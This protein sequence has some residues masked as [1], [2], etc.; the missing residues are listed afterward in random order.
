MNRSPRYCPIPGGITV[1]VS[2]D[3]LYCWNFLLFSTLSLCI[4]KVFRTSLSMQTPSF[5]SQTLKKRKTASPTTIHWVQTT[6]YL[7]SSLFYNNFLFLQLSW[8]LRLCRPLWTTY[9]TK[10]EILRQNITLKLLTNSFNSY[11]V[12]ATPKQGK[13]LVCVVAARCATKMWTSFRKR[14]VCLGFQVRS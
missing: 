2:D 4:M 14:L 1:S 3:L 9:L 12:C 13:S 8:S 6:F 7:L 11:L 10:S 5:F